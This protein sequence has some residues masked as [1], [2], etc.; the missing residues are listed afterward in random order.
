MKQ[1]LKR[2]IK[3]LLTLVVLGLLFTQVDL[4]TLLT[5]ISKVKL[6]WIFF[7]ITLSTLMV[8]VRWFNWHLL[9]K[10]GFGETDYKETFASLLGSM[11]FALVTPAR[12]GDL[13]RVAFLKSGRRLEASGL[14]LVDRFIDL[15]VVLILGTIGMLIFFGTKTLPL[16][17]FANIF[18]FV[19]IFK[20][21]FFLKLGAKLIP[22]KK[23]QSITSDAILGLSRLSLR[24]LAINLSLTVILNLLDILSLYVLVRALGINNFKAVVFAYPLVMLSTLLPITISGIGVRESTSV[25][26]FALFSIAKEVAFNAT[27]LAYLINSLFPALVGLYFFR[28]L[29]K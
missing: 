12:V 21:D 11:S 6:E 2:I 20:L 22:H 28:Q 10:T 5:V 1:P 9:V 29:N 18:L 15:S 23:I 26:L 27:F 4:K 24:A 14:V 8:I 17:L 13:S 19:G 7:A 3:L 16:L 25:A